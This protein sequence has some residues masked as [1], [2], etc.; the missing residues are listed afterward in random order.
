MS[1][2]CRNYISG[3]LQ[4]SDGRL[5]AHF[6]PLPTGRLADAASARQ[7]LPDGP[8]P[9]SRRGVCQTAIWQTASARHHVCQTALCNTPSA[10]LPLPDG[11]LTDAATGRQHLPDGPLP[12]GRRGV[13]QMAS[14]RHGI[15]QTPAVC[16]TPSGR[17]PSG[18]RRN[19]QTV[20]GRGPSGRRCL[21]EGCLADG[22]WQMWCLADAVCPM[23]VC[24]MLSGRHLLGE[25]RLADGIWQTPS[26]RR[27]VLQTPRLP[28]TVLQTPLSKTHKS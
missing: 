15:W 6:C 27:G 4:L 9:S 1:K 28:D 11:T 22:V 16:Q 8:L 5:G 7:R 23:A 3:P 24:Q 17:G 20:S 12:S 18:R 25:G 19:W 14:G 21:A 10:R 2:L 13:C 26:A